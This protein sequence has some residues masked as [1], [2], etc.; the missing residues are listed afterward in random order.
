MSY[1]IYIKY[2]MKILFSNNVTVDL[3]ID[4]S[5]IGKIYQKTY[6]HLSSL[7]IPFSAWDNGS[8]YKDTLGYT[9]LVDQLI[10]YAG[11][12]SINIDKQ[13]VLNQ[14]QLYFNSIHKI[15]E[16]Q[17]DG[18]PG[19]LNFHEHIHM[20]E[21]YFHKRPKVFS[22]DYREK[23][24]P[25]EKPFEWSWI[26]TTT[27][28]IKAGDIYVAWSELGKTPYSYWHNNEPPVPERMCELI[29]PWLK[30]IPKIKIALEDIDRLENIKVAEF[31]TWWEQHKGPWLQHWN[32]SDWTTH[33]IF[34]V[35]VF[36]R[37]T[38]LDVLLA[39][40]EN[41]ITPTRVLV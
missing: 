17:Y 30:L 33:D 39:Q 18:S 13:R 1:K 41:N 8:N 21:G 5:P 34:S 16:K 40:A 36:G 6:K 25:L 28:N 24:G 20:C 7:P 12:L 15:Y 14:D 27:T 4:N 26:D 35:N 2:Q 11:R 38:Q 10:M 3:E 32:L 31:E 19:W 23:M 9:E 37:T 29:K 22:I